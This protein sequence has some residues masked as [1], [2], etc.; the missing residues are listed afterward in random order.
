MPHA[1][2]KIG[3]TIIAE[4]DKWESVEGNVYFPRSSLKNSA[5]TF[6]LIQSDASTFCP[7]KGTASYYDIAVKETGTIISDAAWYY[8]E[9]YEAAKNIG[10]HVAFYKGKVD[11]A[12]E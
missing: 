5:G 9:P 2:A 12:V 1:T 10:G 4:A 7:W 3:D 6:D 8:A 11:V